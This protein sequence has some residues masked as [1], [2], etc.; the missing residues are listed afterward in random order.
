MIIIKRPYRLKMKNLILIF[1]AIAVNWSLFSQSDIA[2]A[3][4]M[5]QDRGEIYVGI[6]LNDLQSKLKVQLLSEIISIDNIKED[7]IWAYANK[8]EFERFL[9][10]GLDFELLTPPS[11]LH[12]PFMLEG[13]A[14]RQR[15]DWDFYPT[16]D[17]YVNIM[18]QFVT[19]YPDL[20]ELVTIATLESGHQLLAIHINDIIGTEQDEPEFLYTA[21]MHGDETAG[22]VLTLH[23]IE[24]LLSNYGNDDQVTH[25]VSNID[26][27]INP[28]ANPDGTYAAG[29]HTVFGA[30]RGNANYIDLNRNF[31]DPED[32]TNPDGNAH[33]EETIAFMEF[34]N[35]NNFVMSANMHGGTEVCNYPWDTY[36]KRHADDD[37]WIYVCRQYADTAQKYSPDGY[38]TDLDNGI[39]NGYDWYS[40]SGGRQDYMNYFHHCREFTL[41]LSDQKLVPASQLEDFWEYNYR[42]FLNYM[43]KVLFGFRGIITNS[44]NGEPIAAQVFIE[45]HDEDESQVFSGFTIGKLFPAGE[46][47]FL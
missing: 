32:G 12:Q 45:D 8:L 33:Q 29:D 38:L 47:W 43:E 17:G 34:A 26:I 9:S 5:V 27:W 20:C 16:Y 3:Q 24:Y 46:I 21:A 36:S 15:T 4:K 30:T 1:L 18:N 22:Y 13:N 23:L 35:D 42:S 2:K 11:M 14:A 6:P 7:K 28:L 41:E 44:A 31:P 10:L 37:W 25:L 40:I 39:T 19:D